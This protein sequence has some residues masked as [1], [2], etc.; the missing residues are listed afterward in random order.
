MSF[1]GGE[2]NVVLTVRDVGEFKFTTSQFW[3]R[4]SKVANLFRGVGKFGSGTLELWIQ[5]SKARNPL[6]GVGKC[7]SGTLESSKV[8]MGCRDGQVWGFGTLDPKF[9]IHCGVS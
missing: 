3:I 4:S 2:K 7:K 8:V 1:S 6:R 5:S 9:Q